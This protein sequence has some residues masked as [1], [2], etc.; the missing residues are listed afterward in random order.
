MH[1]LQA[2]DLH[3]VETYWKSRN[4]VD[5]G[6]LSYYIRWLQGE[7]GPYLDTGH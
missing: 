6:H 3:D 5:E 4:L 7:S 1:N 2:I